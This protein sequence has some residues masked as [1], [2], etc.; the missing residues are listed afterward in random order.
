MN[1]NDSPWRAASSTAQV[2]GLQAACKSVDAQ[3][4][5]E[6]HRPLRLP[7]LPPRELL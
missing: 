1:R 5:R 6:L 7:A 2:H 3:G 4:H